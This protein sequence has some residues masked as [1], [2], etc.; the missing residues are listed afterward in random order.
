MAKVVVLTLLSLFSKKRKKEKT[1]AWYG[2]RSGLM[3]GPGFVVAKIVVLALL[4]LFSKKKKRKKRQLGLG[5]GF[6]VG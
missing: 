4:F 5:M 1:W 3:M 6:G 2:L